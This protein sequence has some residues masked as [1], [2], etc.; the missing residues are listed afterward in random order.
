MRALIICITLAV[1]CLMIAHENRTIA[2]VGDLF[3]ILAGIWTVIG[4]VSAGLQ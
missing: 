1:V 4:I 2:G 3:R